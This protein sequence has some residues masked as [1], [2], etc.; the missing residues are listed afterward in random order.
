MV[1]EKMQRKVRFFHSIGNWAHFIFLHLIFTH[2]FALPTRYNKC[3][4]VNDSIYFSIQ[5]TYIALYVFFQISK[6]NM[7]QCSRR[8]LLFGCL[9]YITLKE[10]DVT[11]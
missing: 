3:V 11:S 9:Q 6:C 8:V 1:C 2:I 7:A 4:S 5:S 10:T